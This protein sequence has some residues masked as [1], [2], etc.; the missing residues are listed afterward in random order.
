MPPP[1]TIGRRSLMQG[2]LKGGLVLAL[3]PH[4]AVAGWRTVAEIAPGAPPRALAATHANTVAIIAD[5]ILPRTDTPSATDVGVVA[6]IDTVAADYLSDSQRTQF[7]D[8]IAAIDAH[9]LSLAGARIAALPAGVVA[10]VIT[11]LDA[12]CGRKHLSAAERGYT[13]LKELV[14]HGYFTSEQVQKD[15]LRVPIIP[16]RFDPSVPVAPADAK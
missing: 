13:Q 2:L 5:A 12:A 7:L 8:G 3:A 9:A 1:P 11:D 16:G 10:G 15:I 6:W 14:I 4:A